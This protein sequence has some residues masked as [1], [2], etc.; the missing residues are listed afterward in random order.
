V[1]GWIFK[2]RAPAGDPRRRDPGAVLTFAGMAI[3][4]PLLLFLVLRRSFIQGLT[5][6]AVR[7]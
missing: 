3:V 2:M 7:R 5:V 4:I 6:G 1:F